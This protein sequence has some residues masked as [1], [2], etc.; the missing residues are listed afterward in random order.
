MADSVTIDSETSLTATFD[1]GV[2]VVMV[3]EVPVVKFLSDALDTSGTQPLLIH[4][5]IMNTATLENSLIV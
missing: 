5:A 3:T 1:N 2:P 4:T